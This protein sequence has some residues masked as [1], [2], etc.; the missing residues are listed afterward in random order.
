MLVTSQQDRMEIEKHITGLIFEL[1]SSR[2]NAKELTAKLDDLHQNV[3][4]M[5]EH[6]YVLIKTFEESEHNILSKENH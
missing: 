4:Q 1:D 3:A 5:E 2:H 6:N